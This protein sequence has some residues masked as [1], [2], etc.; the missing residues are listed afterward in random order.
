MK[1]LA[2][3]LASSCGWAY[4]D[5]KTLTSGV[6]KFAGSAPE[7]FRQLNEWLENL[8]LNEKRPDLVA[9]EK[10]HFRGYPATFL[11]VGFATRVEEFFYRKGVKCVSI[12][13]GTMK[14]HIAGSGKAEKSEVIKAVK[15]KFKITKEIGDDEADALSCL[16]YVMDAQNNERSSLA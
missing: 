3:D 1:F 15:A 16:A 6:R 10:P 9:Y 13:S 2:F 11:L 14:K 8:Y 12:H 4:H 7:K 5:G